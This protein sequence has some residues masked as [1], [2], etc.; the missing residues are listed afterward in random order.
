MSLPTETV[1]SPGSGLV[2]Q[3]YYG[4][5]VTDAYHNAILTA[6][7]DYQS[8]F[9]A[10]V[11]V[12]MSFD[13][14]PGND[15]FAA[16]NSYNV[17]KVSYDTESGGAGADTFHFSQDAGVDRV[18]DFHYA[19]GDRVQVDPGTTYTLHQDGAD[20]IID[21]GGGNEMILVGVQLSSLPSGWIFG[22]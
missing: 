21:T 13:L 8:H 14:Q 19:E 20:T 17:V 22:A 2:F 15:D 5:G 12:M 10:P 9:T 7:H 16:R 6:E 3:N 4:A 11:T 18:L 1:T